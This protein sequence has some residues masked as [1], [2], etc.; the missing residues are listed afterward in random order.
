M[1]G[2][3]G[4]KTTKK[5]RTGKIC[6]VSNIPSKEDKIMGKKKGKKSK[7]KTK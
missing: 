5:T 7:E 1:N 2:K 3:I 4:K 6:P